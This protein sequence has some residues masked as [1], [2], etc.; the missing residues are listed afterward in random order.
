MHM[1]FSKKKITKSLYN[2]QKSM[3]SQGS[4]EYQAPESPIPLL[5]SIG[6]SLPHNTAAS[7]RKTERTDSWNLHQAECLDYGYMQNIL[8]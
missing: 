6:F 3:D 8:S 1:V 4:K 2:I 5:L 7:P